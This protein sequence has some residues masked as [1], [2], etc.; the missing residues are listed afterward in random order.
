MEKSIHAPVTPPKLI[1]FIDNNAGLN[2]D[3]PTHSKF[4]NNSCT[5]FAPR[6]SECQ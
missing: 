2:C 5:A 6:N 1:T 3:P 4:I